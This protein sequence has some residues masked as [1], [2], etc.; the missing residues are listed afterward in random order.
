MIGINE[1][2]CPFRSKDEIHDIAD[3]VRRR[4]WSDELPVNIEIIIEKHGLH[5]IPR[6]LPNNIDAFLKSDM[7]GIVVN[8]QGYTDQR[9][10]NRLRFSFAHELGHYILHKDIIEKMD[11]NSFDEYFYFLQNYP[12]DQYSNFEYQANE[13]GGRV[14]VP[15]PELKNEIDKA[16][17]QLRENGLNYLIG[18][19]SDSVLARISPTLCKPFYVSAKCIEIRAKSEGLWPPQEYMN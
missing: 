3:S 10:E 12:E 17:F 7:E 14:L 18:K 8:L 19:N 1:F 4:F 2:K 5:I 6:D 9:W 11:F 13:F 16:L 15:Y